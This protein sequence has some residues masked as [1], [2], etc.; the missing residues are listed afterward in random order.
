NDGEMSKPRHW[1]QINVPY[2]V[3]VIVCAPT[4]ASAGLGPAITV[5]AHL[6]GASR[7]SDAVILS[8]N[9]E[10]VYDLEMEAPDTAYSVDPGQ[11]LVIPITTTNEGNGPD[12]YDLRTAS[13]TD[14][15]GTQLLWNIE[16]PRATLSELHRD[17]SETVDVKINIPGQ[18]VAGNYQVVLKAFS[19]EYYDGTDERDA[20]LFDITVNQFHDMQIWIDETVESQIKTTAPGRTVRYLLNVT[21]NGNVPDIPTLHNHTK[22]GDEWNPTPDMGS[23]SKWNIEFAMVEDF[24]TELPREIPCTVLGVGEAAPEYGCAYHDDGTWSLA[25]MPAYTTVQIV[26]IVDISPTATLANREIGIKVMSNYGSSPNG[27]TDETPSWADGCTI[28]SD[29]DGILDNVYPCDTNEQVL[30]IRLRAPDLEI[31]DYQIDSDNRDAPVGEMIPVVVE[32]AKTGNVHATDINIVLC[33]DETED[34]LR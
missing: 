28:D 24:D 19:E 7:V 1:S 5:K 29:N 15:N 31:T 25:E 2:E 27:D 30:R 23:L 34:N 26:V 3:G 13:I 8:T 18:I 21:N 10:H 16:I 17:D 11:Q 12:R 6:Q 14:S 33:E 9:V 20:I 4:N 22:G 32:I